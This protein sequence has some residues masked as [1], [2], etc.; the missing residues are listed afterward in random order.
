MFGSGISEPRYLGW[1]IP[2]GL[3]LLQ[4]G[5]HGNCGEE[6]DHGPKKNIWHV[7]VAMATGS[8][9]IL[10]VQW[11]ALLPGKENRVGKESPVLFFQKLTPDQLQLSTDGSHKN[12]DKIFA[13]R[14]LLG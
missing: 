9:N 10:P 3:E 14:I 5:W 4:G 11:S 1:E 2:A 6:Q 12:L 8:P 7:G 13:F